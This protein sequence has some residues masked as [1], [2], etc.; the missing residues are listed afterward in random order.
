MVSFG[1]GHSQVGRTEVGWE[2]VRITTGLTLE[3]LKEK[4]VRVGS[5]AVPARDFRGPTVF[6]DEKD[7][8]IGACNYDNRMGC[9]FQLS[10]L[11]AMKEND[12]VPN[13]DWIFAF[14]KQEEVKGNGIKPLALREKPDVLIGIDGGPIFPGSDIT[15]DGGCVVIT[16]DKLA[17]YNFEVILA[18]QDAAR[19]VGQELQYLTTD[20]AYTDASLAQQ[21][22]GPMRIGFFGFTAD[23]AHGYEMIKY[24]MLKQYFDLFYSFVKTFNP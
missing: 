17:D 15:W 12:L 6:G 5:V 14:P 7:P 23:T 18:I 22:G 3:Q 20:V 9:A 8:L 13:C 24:S 11:H 10:I 16:K 1:A 19:A 21:S 2:D 4:G